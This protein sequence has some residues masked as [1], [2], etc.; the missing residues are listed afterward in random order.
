MSREAQTNGCDGEHGLP[1]SD[2]AWVSWVSASV[3]RNYLTRN[4]LIDCLDLHGESH[5]FVKYNDLPGYD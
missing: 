4:P 2:D 1:E 3:I 5:G